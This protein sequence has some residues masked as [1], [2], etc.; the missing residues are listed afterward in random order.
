MAAR[1]RAAWAAAVLLAVGCRGGGAAEAAV[2]TAEEGSCAADGGGGCDAEAGW[3][4]KRDEFW[5]EMR[6]HG[7]QIKLAPKTFEEKS[8]TG[9]GNRSRTG[10]VLTHDVFYGRSIVKIPR[11]ALLSIETAQPMELRKEV[12][13]FLFEKQTL[14]KVFNATGED[15]AHLLSLAYPL[16]AMRRDPA[17]VFREWL[18]ELRHEQLTVLELTP[19]QR[20]VLKGTTVDGAYEEM[21]RNR[22][23]IRHTAGNFSFFRQ[24]PVGKAEASWAIAVIMRHARVVHPHQDVRETRHPR[25]YL[26]PFRELLNVSLHPDAGVALPFQEEIVLDGKREEEVVVQI[27]KRDMPKGEEV[28]LWPGR[29]SNSELVVRHGIR[30]EKNPL[31]IGRNVTQ[32]P[33]W[34]DNRESNIRKEYDKYNCSSLESFELRLS[35][36]G[37]PTRTFVRCYRVSW[38]LSNGWYSPALLKRRRDLER[39]PPPAKYGKDDWLAWTQADQELNRMLL[40]YCRDMRERLKASIDSELAEDFR[41]SKDPL[42]KLLWQLRVEESKTFKECVLRAKDIV[43]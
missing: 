3:R 15:A 21:T 24:D 20:R 10:M 29:M 32:P 30:F 2:G 36:A 39:W 28:F 26:F 18:D 35:P 4:A 17:S 38:F 16:I 11:H 19:R 33:N 42:D 37:A 22:D 23:L 12:N 27:A 6:R 14:A 8:P 9:K 34:V 1:R 13:E 5:E 25:M 40:E 41:K 31:G 43:A 7:L